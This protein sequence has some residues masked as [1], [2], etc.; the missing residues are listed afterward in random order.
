MNDK[1]FSE[2]QE[3]SKQ[4]LRMQPRVSKGNNLIELGLRHGLAGESPQFPEYLHYYTAWA[5]GY[6]EYLLGDSTT[7]VA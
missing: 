7:P 6:R 3:N 2:N 1:V 4:V 5:S